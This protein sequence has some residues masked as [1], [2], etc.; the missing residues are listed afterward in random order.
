VDDNKKKMD[1]KEK[2]Y[3]IGGLTLIITFILAAIWEF[4]LMDRIYPPT[5]IAQVATTG[6]RFYSLITTVLFVAIALVVPVLVFARKD[7]AGRLL[8]KETIKKED[9][10]IEFLDGTGTVMAAYEWHKK[11]N[12]ADKNEAPPSDAE[13]KKEP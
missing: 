10:E 2:I 5:D 11:E 7:D 9:K 6:E 4:V 12:P 1:F 13:N 3:R 8:Q